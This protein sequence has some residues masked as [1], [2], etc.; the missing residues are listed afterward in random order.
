MRSTRSIVAALVTVALVAPAAQ[1]AAAPPDMHASTAIAAAKA[2]EKQDLRSPDARD[3][4][5]HR[6]R[7][8][9]TVDAPGATAVGSAS[10][11]SPAEPAPAPAPAPKS[12]DGG[13]DWTLIG[14]G[15]AAAFALCSGLALVVTRRPL[16]ARTVA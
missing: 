7:L 3:A 1:A 2:R 13:L 16:R 10:V 8:D 12:T 9:L 11:V 4:A 5:L 15:I 14:I 6:S